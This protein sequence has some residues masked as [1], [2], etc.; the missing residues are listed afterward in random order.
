M[1]HDI[2]G[3][4]MMGE[5]YR[6]VMYLHER[7]WHKRFKQW[8][9]DS[10]LGRPSRVFSPSCITVG[11][12]TVF[13]DGVILTAW[14]ECGFGA[15]IEIGN[16]CTIGAFNHITAA[17]GIVIGDGFLSGKWVTITD[18]SHGEFNWE[19]LQISPADRKIF[20]KGP[21]VIGK[22]V[23]IGD[24]ATILPGVTIGDG[25]IVGANSVVTKDIPSYCM[26]A[27]NP[28]VVI[29]QIKR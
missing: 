10:I 21:V 16:N 24:K 19:N 18:N 20:S 9:K 13:N 12:H 4:N 17:R 27:G 25:V 8:G 2:L 5:L 22:N 6:R 15:E 7:R 14:P 23:W 11:S 29:K 28:A 3:S 26:A 1:L